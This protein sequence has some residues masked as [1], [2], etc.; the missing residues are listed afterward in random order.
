M[1]KTP[2]LSPKPKVVFDPKMPRYDYRQEDGKS[3]SVDR[4]R[5]ENLKAPLGCLAN[6]KAGG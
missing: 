1:A 6:L 2:S 4:K 3:L 5:G